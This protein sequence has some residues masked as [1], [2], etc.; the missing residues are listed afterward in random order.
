M[1]V[2]ILGTGRIGTTSSIATSCVHVIALLSAIVALGCAEFRPMIAAPSDLEDYRAFRVS[3]ADGT[4]LSRAA[5]Y[6][7][8]H[9]NGAWAHEVKSAFDEEEPRYFAAAQQSREGARRYLADLPEGPHAEAALAL[10]IAFGS[11]MQEAELRDIARR[12][13]ADDVKLEVLAKQRRAVGESIL[14][15][16]G[17]LLD[18][19]VY[20]VSRTEAP[21]TLRALL[22][23]RG[24]TWGSVPLRHEEDHF[25]LLPTR[26]ERESRLL[27]IEVSLLEEKDVVVGAVVEGNDLLVR[28]MEAEQMVRLDSS[29]SEDRRRA[30]AFAMSRLAGALERRFPTAS[31]VDVRKS[32]ELYHRTC[33][34][35][36]GIVLPGTKAGDKDAIILH[37]PRARTPDTLPPSSFRRVPSHRV[38]AAPTDTSVRS[39][40]RFDG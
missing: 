37:A 31:C 2:G 4:R 7:R 20:G 13:R 36:E 17:I 34:G 1:I 21:P 6:L 33:G 3:A 29:E 23:G 11:S 10:L 28:W 40:V 9:P 15:S 25:F 35:W 16:V 27:T 19:D 22:L 32:P 12:V 30:H 5:R 18:E 39:S 8:R 26:P 14:S 24:S 38:V